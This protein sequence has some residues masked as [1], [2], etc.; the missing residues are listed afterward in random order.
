MFSAKGGPKVTKTKTTPLPHKTGHQRASSVKDCGEDSSGYDRM[1]RASEFLRM[2]LRSVCYPH[3]C[4]VWPA[5]RSQ[6]SEDSSAIFPFPNKTIC[7]EK[8]GE[9]RAGLSW[10]VSMG[11]F[12]WNLIGLSESDQKIGLS[13][14]PIPCALCSMY[15]IVA[16][17]VQY[18]RTHSLP[19]PLA[20]FH[21]L[22]LVITEYTVCF[23]YLGYLLFSFFLYGG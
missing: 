6:E 1:N 20:C 9:V 12:K 19:N 22:V 2:L 23:T 18:A 7:L 14:S 21:P 10:G 11:A 8:S 16:G 3:W 15:Q 17:D 4:R 13:I 5:G